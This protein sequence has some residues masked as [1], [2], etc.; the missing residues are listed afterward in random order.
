MVYFGIGCVSYETN[1][2]IALPCHRYIHD[3]IDHTLLM[4]EYTINGIADML[5]VDPVDEIT[6]GGIRTFLYKINTGIHAIIGSFF[7]ALDDECE[8]GNFE[9]A[10]E[11]AMDR[12][13]VGILNSAN[14]LADFFDDIGWTGAAYTIRE[15]IAIMTD[16]IENLL[17]GSLFKDGCEYCG[18]N[19]ASTDEWLFDGCRAFSGGVCETVRQACTDRGIL[20]SPCETWQD[21]DD[22]AT[23]DTYPNPDACDVCGVWNG[24]CTNCNAPFGRLLALARYGMKTLLEYGLTAIGMSID[25]GEPGSILIAF[26]DDCWDWIDGTIGHVPTHF[27]AWLAII[28]DDDCVMN[29]DAKV[30]EMFVYY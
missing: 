8:E 15:F 22:C 17:T 9:R 10:Y 19:G 3:V 25:P 5:S 21:C 29:T 28:F 13:I 2:S 4:I 12:G 24:T 30:I 26:V 11:Y 20:F 7:L 18:M 27:L 16:L 23:C 1:A 14:V 6:L